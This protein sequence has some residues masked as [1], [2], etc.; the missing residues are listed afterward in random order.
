M[1]KTKASL[2]K[3]H[4]PIQLCQG[5]S[6]EG[7]EKTKTKTESKMT[8]TKSDDKDITKTKSSRPKREQ[9]VRSIMPR[10]PRRHYLTN[11]ETKTE[12]KKWQTQ[13]P[14]D[15]AKALPAKEIRQ[16]VKTRLLLQT[17]RQ[18]QRARERDFK[19]QTSLLRFIKKEQGHTNIWNKDMQVSQNWS[20]L[21]SAIALTVIWKYTKRNKDM[22]ISGKRTCKYL[23]IG[24]KCSQPYKN[25]NIWEWI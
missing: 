17:Q 16:S 19:E 2:R 14:K 12:T 8:K 9:P 10:W 5:K 23:R 20:K 1:T 22:Q 25:V 7:D 4:Q 3:S 11:K 15:K 13:R 18:E 6:W 24:L 21:L